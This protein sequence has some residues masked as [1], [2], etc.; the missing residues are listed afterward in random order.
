MSS[1]PTCPPSAPSRSNLIQAPPANRWKGAIHTPWAVAN[2]PSHGS[3]ARIERA[4]AD[5]GNPGESNPFP[6][7]PAYSRLFLAYGGGGV[8]KLGA[9]PKLHRGRPMVLRFAPLLLAL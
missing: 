4:V 8:R 7:I 5:T 3:L 1:M 2:R 6:L 9:C